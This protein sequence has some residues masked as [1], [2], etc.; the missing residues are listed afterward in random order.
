[1]DKVFDTFSKDDILKVVEGRISWKGN[2]LSDEDVA[3]LKGQVAEFK[4]SFLWKVLKA[5]LQWFAIKS[6][7]E[8]GKTAEDLRFARLMGNLVRI[9]DEKLNSLK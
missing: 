9:V 8:Q 4:N 5:E 1:M 7:M 6:L 3:L 2:P